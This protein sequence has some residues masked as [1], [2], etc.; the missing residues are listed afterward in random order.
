[1]NEYKKTFTKDE[2]RITV[3]G[4]LDEELGAIRYDWCV[5]QPG[6]MFCSGGYGIDDEICYPTAESALTS[7]INVATNETAKR[8]ELL[9][10][11][12]LE[13]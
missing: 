12:L 13:I 6:A 7:A 10:E 1:M 2:T 4:H 3:Y 11:F 8:R 9:M 5:E